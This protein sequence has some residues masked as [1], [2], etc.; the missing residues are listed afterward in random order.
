MV[1]LALGE[2]KDKA[3]AKSRER[4]EREVLLWREQLK[5]QQEQ[6]GEGEEDRHGSAL[7]AVVAGEVCV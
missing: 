6:K 2:G 7:V 5:V 4:V 3:V 1:G